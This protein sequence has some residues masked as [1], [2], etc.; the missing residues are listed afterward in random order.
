MSF[1][2]IVLNLLL[3]VNSVQE[4][5]RT[6]DFDI[7]ARLPEAPKVPWEETVEVLMLEEVSLLLRLSVDKLGMFERAE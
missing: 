6:E 2:T 3:D 7:P 5:E 1:F 4:V